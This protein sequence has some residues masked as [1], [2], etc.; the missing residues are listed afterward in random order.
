[1][2]WWLIVRMI[3]FS[4]WVVIL[5]LAL[6]L[7]TVKNYTQLEID[8]AYEREVKAI[9]IFSIGLDPDKR[10]P[11]ER[12]GQVVSTWLGD[13]IDLIK[14]SQPSG[15]VAQSVT[16]AVEN[17][18]TSWWDE[19]KPRLKRFLP[20]AW[21]RV[22][23]Y[24]VMYLTCIWLFFFAFLIGEHFA[25]KK[26]R[27]GV[28]KRNV[29]PIWIRAILWLIRDISVACTGIVIFPPVVYWIIPNL[30]ICSITVMLWR[31][32]SIQGLAFLSPGK[33]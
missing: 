20:L 11:C 21:I 10:L 31:A 15:R 29:L 17:V 32:Y 26:I 19:T 28:H 24:L 8:D 13:K 6:S 33:T 27:S 12:R 3:G 14:M 30:L 22:E 4:G 9:R 16:S 25:R 23:T 7:L 1:M 18:P 5:C 2:F